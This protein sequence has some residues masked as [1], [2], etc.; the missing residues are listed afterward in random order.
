MNGPDSAAPRKPRT[1]ERPLWDLLEGM[2]G[3]QA[4]LVAYD[5]KLF[6]LLAAE[7][8]TLP[9]VA[10][11]LGIACRPAEALLNVCVA[12]GL[13]R[14]SDDRYHLTALAED[15][16]LESSPT[17]FGDFLAG[18][19][20]DPSATSF[21]SVK[22]A[23]L[24]N[25]SPF[26]ERQDW[27]KRLRE[28]PA[29]ARNFIRAM[30]AHS[31]APALAWPDCLD[32]ADC[33]QM[34]D[35]GGGSGAH[36]IGAALRW[37]DLHATVFDLEPVCAVAT[38]FVGKYGLSGRIDTHAGNMWTDPLPPAD[39]HFYSDIFHDWPPDRAALLASKSYHALAPGGRLIVHEMVYDDDKAGPFTVS[40][41]NV[42][43]L[44]MTEGQQYSGRELTAMLTGAGFADVAVTPTFGYWSVVVGRKPPTA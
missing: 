38:E 26:A 40:A 4:V 3:T 17:Y 21:A 13:L 18:A 35:I 23:I 7:P 1:D 10:E 42:A 30:H 44:M 15:Y 41:Y 36:A 39:L 37:T 28:Q 34:L 25:A 6:P 33:R 29:F 31:M 24:T 27:T 5:L 11:A 14:R 8:R 12:A 20:A 43:L 32:L 22:K 19:I 9:G 16:L 2:L